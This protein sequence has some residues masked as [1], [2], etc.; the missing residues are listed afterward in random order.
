MRNRAFALFASIITMAA[1]PAFAQ[2]ASGPS[3]EVGGGVASGFLYPDQ[4]T[5]FSERT[6]ATFDA[7]VCSGGWCGTIWTA[8]TGESET[9]ETDLIVSREFDTGPVTIRLQGGYYLVAGEDIWSGITSATLP[10]SDSL[11]ITASY[12]VMG[13]GYETNVAKLAGNYEH[14][15][16]DRV[17]G[18]IEVAISHDTSIDAQVWSY[19]V[20]VS[21]A[22]TEEL[23]VRGYAQGFESQVGDGYIVGVDVRR[24]WP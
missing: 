23:T 6:T 16:T 18:D 4:A 8:Q 22:L 12:E 2:E 9:S 17:V 15:F 1:T 11:S 13:G 20:G 14:S 5:V 24:R 7:T 19:E 21:Y 10:V 3:F